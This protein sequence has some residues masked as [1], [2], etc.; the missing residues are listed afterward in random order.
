MRHLRSYGDGQ[1]R[2]SRHQV[3][4]TQSANQLQGLI[5]S[6][7]TTVTSLGHV[8]LDDLN[9]ASP[10]RD[11][12]ADVYQIPLAIDQDKSTRSSPRNFV[13]EVT[14][15]NNAD[16]SRKYHLDISLHTLAIR[17]RFDQN[18]STPKATGVEY[19]KGEHLY[20]ADPNYSESTG[21]AGYVAASKDVIISAGTFNTPQ[22]LKL[23]GVGPHQELESFGINVV[24]DLPGV[25]SNMQDRYEVSIVEEADSKF[26]VS[27][28]CTFL[29]DGK[30][31]PCL[32]Q[33]QTGINVD[34]RGPYTTSGAALGVLLKSST[35]AAS[36]PVDTFVIGTPGVF[37]GFFPG[38]AYNSVI[39]GNRWSWLVLKAHSHNNAGTVKLRST[40][41]YDVPQI[42]F[43]S[44]DTG[45]TTDG[46]DEKDVQALY[47]GLKFGREAFDKLIP[48]DGTKW[49]EVQPGRNISTAAQVK[50]YIKDEAWG[51][52]ACCT[53]SIGADDDPNA[54]LDSNFRVRGIDNLRVVDASAFSKIPGT[55]I[56]LPIYIISEKA[57]DVIIEGS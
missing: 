11:Q 14:N 52:H 5:T 32:E 25:G 42:D 22:L 6:L 13:L 38:F 30:P 27:K 36:D 20:A 46:G 21:T 16:G 39:W 37:A 9:S 41:P 56:S 24:K 47:E 28:D 33:W 17:I 43:R 40:S 34:G 19:L 23:S 35:A 53:A 1:G 45:N 26:D 48:I 2:L 15:A 54:V 3:V 8:L 29:Y 31:D 12:T 4:S 51:H 7:I 44:F 18:G 10:T 50:E 49:T 55:F 57:A